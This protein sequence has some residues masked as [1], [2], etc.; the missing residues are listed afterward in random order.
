MEVR[1]GDKRFLVWLRS[2]VGSTQAPGKLTVTAVPGCPLDYIYYRMNYNPE[3]EGTSKRLGLGK[4]V[5]VFK[6]RRQRQADP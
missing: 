4:I 5:H 6:V 3:V 2:Q 1:T